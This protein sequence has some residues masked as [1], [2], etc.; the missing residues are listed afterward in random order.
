[1]Q[2][3]GGGL[4]YPGGQ[5][6]RDGAETRC[7]GGLLKGCEGLLGGFGPRKQQP[8]RIKTPT[9]Q[10][11][12]IRGT[13]IA[14]AGGDKDKRP[15]GCLRHGPGGDGQGKSRRG[16]AVQIGAGLGFM[17]CAARQGRGLCL[18]KPHPAPARRR[19]FQGAHPTAQPLQQRPPIRNVQFCNISVRHLHHNA[20]GFLLFTKCSIAPGP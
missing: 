2:P 11:R 1:M 10:A 16:G 18:A 6:P 4:V 13:E 3:A 9:L 17:D 14:A 8:R 5:K 12:G 7:A 20:S 19:A 15:A